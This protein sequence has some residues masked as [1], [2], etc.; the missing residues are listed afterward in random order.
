MSGTQARPPPW[1]P[2]PRGES[3]AQAPCRSCDLL[4]AGWLWKLLWMWSGVQSDPGPWSDSPEAP[5]N[6]GPKSGL[7]PIP[8]C[9]RADGGWGGRGPNWAQGSD[10]AQGGWPCPRTPSVRDTPSQPRPLR[11]LAP[12]LPLL[13]SPLPPFL[14]QFLSQFLSQTDTADPA[15]TLAGLHPLLPSLDSFKSLALRGSGAVLSQSSGC[16]VSGE[17]L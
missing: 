14:L 4:R 15:S 7:S 16:R 13:L 1:V 8:P 12:C 17:G 9:A 6:Y 11:P 3:P 5:S 2:G 10:P